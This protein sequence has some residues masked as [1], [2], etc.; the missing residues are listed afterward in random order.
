MK[1]VVLL[2]NLVFFAL[3]NILHSSAW[4]E[5][6]E[7]SADPIYNPYPNTTL[8]EDYYPYVIYSPNNF[9]GDGDAVPYKMW[10]QGPNGIA[11][12][13]S[14]D[15]K[16]WQLKGDTNLSNAYHATVL[17]DKN[18]FGGGNYNYRIWFWLGVATG[19]PDVILYSYSKDGVTWLEP[20]PISQD[21]NAPI[22][23]GPFGTYFYNLYGPGFII[24]HPNATS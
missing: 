5:W 4:T 1:L 2:Y 6:K 12:S 24:Y 22:V 21:P 18:G 8:F 14:Q 20:Q 19:S 10:H 16:T 15:G 13:Y 9:N 7:F 3:C 17:Y 11:L 23:F